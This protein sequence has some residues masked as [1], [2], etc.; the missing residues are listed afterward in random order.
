MARLQHLG[1][2][3]LAAGLLSACPGEDPNAVPDSGSLPFLSVDLGEDKS[4]IFPLIGRWYPLAEIKRLTDR[5]LTAQ[6]W[7]KRPPTH[8]QIKVDEAIVQCDEGPELVAS[9]G[10]VRTS[11]S[12]G[13]LILD[14]RVPRDYPVQK[15]MVQVQGPRAVVRG[16]P[17]DGQRETV[18]QRFPQYELLTREVLGNNVCAQVLEGRPR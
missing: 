5:S 6:E 4:Q 12:D 15:L 17:C 2:V 1:L 10:G 3:A 18:Y 14:L 16:S 7:C 11:T 9:I 13:A 8:L